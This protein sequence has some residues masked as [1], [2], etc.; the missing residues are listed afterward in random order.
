MRFSNTAK[1]YKN[2]WSGINI[3]ANAKNLKLFNVFRK[4]DKN[5][6]ALISEKP[7]NLKYYYLDDSALNGILSQSKV[8]SLKDEGYKVINEEFITTQRLD[9]ILL[10]CKISNKTDRS[11]RY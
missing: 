8:N 5:I 6:N 4:R 3:D 7:E 10:T 1:L 9:D 11:F 2:G